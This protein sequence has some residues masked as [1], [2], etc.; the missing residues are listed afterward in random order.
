MVSQPQKGVRETSE[1]GKY[2]ESSG[3]ESQHQKVVTGN[4][5]EPHFFGLLEGKNSVKREFVQHRA[6]TS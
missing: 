2:L 1:K 6:T 3:S 5:V 4:D